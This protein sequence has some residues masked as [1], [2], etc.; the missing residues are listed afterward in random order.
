MWVDGAGYHW[1]TRTERQGVEPYDQVDQGE[2]S[3]RRRD[4]THP[5]G[6]A[7][8]RESPQDDEQIMR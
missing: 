2:T 5:I 6:Y 3:A 1:M 7:S 4:G 8:T